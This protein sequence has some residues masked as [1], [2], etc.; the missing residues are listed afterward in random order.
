M[1][2]MGTKGSSHSQNSLLQVNDV[3]VDGA[4]QSGEYHGFSISFM[5]YLLQFFCKVS[6]R[7]LLQVREWSRG[8]RRATAVDHSVYSF[9]RGSKLLVCYHARYL[10][11]GEFCVRF[12]LQ[13]LHVPFPDHQSVFSARRC[14]V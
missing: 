6:L 4:N 5:T 12:S 1:K 11:R 10:P 7:E 3:S 13:S 9:Q 14:E 8:F 2:K